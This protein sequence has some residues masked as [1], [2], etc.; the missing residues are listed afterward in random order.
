MLASLTPAAAVCQALD[1]ME[2]W[3]AGFK[4]RDRVSERRVWLARHGGE[5]G[6]D[7]LQVCSATLTVR[8]ASGLVA[9]GS[10]ILSVRLAAEPFRR[11]LE[12][13]LA[14]RATE[15]P[16]IP[17]VIEGERGIG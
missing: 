12:L 5:H 9:G 2:S 17:A 16:G 8:F 14:P 4:A 11:G 13:L 10:E 15:I 6:G 7:G 1:L 3:L